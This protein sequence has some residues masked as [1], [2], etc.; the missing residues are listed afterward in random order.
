[1]IRNW[2]K[3]CG[4]FVAAVAIQ[5]ATT[6]RAEAGF[7]LKSSLGSLGA[8]DTIDWSSA[9]NAGQT[10]NNPFSIASTGGLT[11]NQVSQ[12]GAVGGEQFMRLD[13]GNGWNGGFASGAHLLWTNGN[14]GPMTIDFGS[15]KNVVS[16]GAFIQSDFFT[17]PFT[18]TIK[19]FDTNGN[20]YDFQLHSSADSSN[21]N[22][23]VFIGVLADN[24]LV[25]H[26]DKI[27]FSVTPDPGQDTAPENFVVGNVSFQTITPLSAVPAPAGA[28]LFG[29]GLTGLGG[30]RLFRRKSRAVA[31]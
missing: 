22:P 25:D 1:M 21:K 20:E 30:C 4:I 31:A 10:I 8:N 18:A 12:V 23:P 29:L 26:I 17:V 2:F 5:I 27:Q 7:T 19:V 3:L 11:G 13:E 15:G 14:N 6:A 28:V 24:V 16:A 9:G